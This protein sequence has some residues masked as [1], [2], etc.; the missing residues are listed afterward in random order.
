[1]NNTFAFLGIIVLCL[2]LPLAYVGLDIAQHEDYEQLAA[3]ITT[4]SLDTDADITLANLPDPNRAASVKSITSTVDT[5]IPV[6]SNYDETT[7]VLTVGGLTA[8][9]TR[10]LEITYQI[11]SATITSYPFL[12]TFII[13]I[14]YLLVLGIIALIIAVV[15]GA[16]RGR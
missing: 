10:S 9:E 15:L 2:L 1:M 4:G 3:G 11:E 7:K 6:V 12:G 5:D 16:F 14:S 13:A 8:E